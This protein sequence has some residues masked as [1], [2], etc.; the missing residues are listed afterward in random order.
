M[1]VLSARAHGARTCSVRAVY[2]ARTHNVRPADT[3]GAFCNMIL[4]GGYLPTA[5][6]PLKCET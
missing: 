1:H 6:S 3:K 5:T 2:F 4:G